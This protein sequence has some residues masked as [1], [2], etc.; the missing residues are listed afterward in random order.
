V[1]GTGTPNELQT[2]TTP[3]SGIVPGKPKKSWIDPL[4]ED[5]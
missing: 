4:T 5:F 2:N 3:S 1:V